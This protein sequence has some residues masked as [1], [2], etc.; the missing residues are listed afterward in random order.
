MFCLST[1]C[2]HNVLSKHCM[3]TTLSWPIHWVWYSLFLIILQAFFFAVVFGHSYPCL[4]WHNC[5]ERANCVLSALKRRL[6]AMCYAHVKFSVLWSASCVHVLDFLLTYINWQ[7]AHCRL[8]LWCQQTHQTKLPLATAP[9]MNYLPYFQLHNVSVTT[10]HF[11][12]M[13]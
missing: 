1:V 7:R 12:L 13:L 2:I 5:N 10:T 3:H 8:P 11:V 9:T 6:R 4:N